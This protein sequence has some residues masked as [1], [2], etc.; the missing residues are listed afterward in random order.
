M[1]L[2]GECD[3]AN[4]VLRTPSLQLTWRG[5]NRLATNGYAFLDAA[6]A[7][8]CGHLQDRTQSLDTGN[9]G[10]AVSLL[11]PLPTLSGGAV[12][13]PLHFHCVSRCNVT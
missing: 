7:W 1:L 5:R 2:C 4:P 6:P 10:I 12:L 13:S 8:I 3:A 9:R 11:R